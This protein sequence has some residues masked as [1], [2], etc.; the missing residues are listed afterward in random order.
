MTEP[1]CTTVIAVHAYRKMGACPIGPIMWRLQEESAT[2]PALS[3]L[4]ILVDPFHT[5]G[6][7]AG[8]IVHPTVPVGIKPKKIVD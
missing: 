8:G 6:L 4:T 5:P 7:P 1:I 2:G 3:A